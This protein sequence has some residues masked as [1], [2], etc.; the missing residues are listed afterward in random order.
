MSALHGTYHGH[1][2]AWAPYLFVYIGNG[3]RQA[4]PGQEREPLAFLKRMEQYLI[5]HGAMQAVVF[6]FVGSV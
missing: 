6:R 5:E 3:I 4:A 2:F 1:F